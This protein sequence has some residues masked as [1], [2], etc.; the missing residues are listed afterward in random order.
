MFSNSGKR[1]PARYFQGVKEQLTGKFHGLTAYTRAP[2]EGRWRTKRTIQRDDI[3][4]Y[5]VMAVRLDK[6][7]WRSFQSMLEERFSQSSVLIRA[8]KITVL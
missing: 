6:K 2:A 3:I 1:F 5:E 7:W 4:V 8:H